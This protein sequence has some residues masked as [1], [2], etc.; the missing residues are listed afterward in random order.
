MVALGCIYVIQLFRMFSVLT[1]NFREIHPIPW[2]TG[3][4]LVIF[5]LSNFPLIERNPCQPS[6]KGLE[7][8]INQLIPILVKKK[9]VLR[10]APWRSCSLQ[11]LVVGL[12]HPL[13]SKCFPLSMVSSV[14]SRVTAI[15]VDKISL[16]DFPNSTFLKSYIVVISVLLTGFS[17]S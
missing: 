1:E 15:E 16:L 8:N 3:C 11:N 4:L 13:S 10:A 12:T 2:S 14:S 5:F 9:K 7:L 6:K 17:V